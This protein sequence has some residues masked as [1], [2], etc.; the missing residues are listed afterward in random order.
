VSC[1]GLKIR[2]KLNVKIARMMKKIL[3]FNLTP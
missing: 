3:L 1:G 2:L